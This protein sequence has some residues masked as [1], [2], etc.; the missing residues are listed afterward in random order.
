PWR[1]QRADWGGSGRNCDPRIRST[2]YLCAS[3]DGLYSWRYARCGRRAGAYC[4]GAEYSGR[5]HRVSSQIHNS[6]VAMAIT[7]TRS[8]A[9][10]FAQLIAEL[11]PRIRAGFMAAVT[12]LSANVNWRELLAN[13]EAGTSKGPLQHLTSVRQPGSSTARP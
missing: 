12:D 6:R 2:G 1:Q 9:R 3:S 7:P 13:L 8:Q 10:L 5:R 4:G 11:E